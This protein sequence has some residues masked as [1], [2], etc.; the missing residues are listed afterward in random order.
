M[1]KY[2][3]TD[4]IHY[5]TIIDSNGR[6]S[7]GRQLYKRREVVYKSA[8]DRMPA[9][10]VAPRTEVAREIFEEMDKILLPLLHEVSQ[11][12]IYAKLRKKYLEGE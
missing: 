4:K 7:W 1:P 6:D 2:V 8:L 9:A 12:Y 11:V 5:T 3:D 10:D